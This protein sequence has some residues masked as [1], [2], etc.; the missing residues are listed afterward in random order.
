MFVARDR[1]TGL[2]Y[3]HRNYMRTSGDDRCGD[4]LKRKEIFSARNPIDLRRDRDCKNWVSINPS[5]N[6]SITR[7]RQT[8]VRGSFLLEEPEEERVGL[9]VEPGDHL[10]E[11]HDGK[12][13]AAEHREQ[14]EFGQPGRHAAALLGPTF[15]L[16]GGLGLA[17]LA[18]GEVLWGGRRW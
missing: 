5:I 4:F 8:C 18:G 17:L 2:G 10:W 12:G 7:S 11:R 6:Q 9:A 13:K 15:V 1:K 14:E 3:S 16:L